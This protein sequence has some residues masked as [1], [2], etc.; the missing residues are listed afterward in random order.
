MSFFSIFCP[1]HHV[2]LERFFLFNLSL[3]PITYRYHLRACLCSCNKGRQSA[4]RGW[5]KKIGHGIQSVS[6]H[7]RNGRDTGK[8]TFSPLPPRSCSNVRMCMQQGG[9][10]GKQE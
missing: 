9:G 1:Y 5:G 2:N 3:T 8:V 6:G 4:T 7:Q 10:D